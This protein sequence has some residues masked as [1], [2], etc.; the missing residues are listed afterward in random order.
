MEITRSSLRQQLQFKR[1]QFSKEFA[2]EAAFLISLS[3]LNLPDWTSVKSIGL[4]CSVKS[5]LPTARLISDFLDKGRSV[6][7][8]KIQ[9][10]ETLEFQLYSSHQPLIPNRFKILEPQRGAVIAPNQL[11]WVLVPLVG[12]DEQGNRLGSGAGYYDRT[13]AFLKKTD[14][15]AK[16]VLIGLAYECQKIAQLESAEWDIPLDRVITEKR[17]YFF[18]LEES[19]IG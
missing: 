7:L 12:F 9:P 15:P 1:S 3:L 4:Y 10:D 5:E 6:Y 19:V 13:F 2:T 14:R 16:P 17:A 11:D 18:K 8:P